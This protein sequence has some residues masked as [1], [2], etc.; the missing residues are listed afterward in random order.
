[1]AP[2][3]ENITITNKSRVWVLA[4]VPQVSPFWRLYPAIPLLGMAPGAILILARIAKVTV[5]VKVVIAIAGVSILG[6]IPPITAMS[7]VLALTLMSSI[8]AVPELSALFYEDDIVL[9]RTFLLLSLIC[10]G[11]FTTTLA[12]VFLRAGPATFPH[13]TGFVAILTGTRAIGLRVVVALGSLLGLPFL[14][15]SSLFVRLDNKPGLV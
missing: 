6:N 14:E 8:I 4:I 1:M 11:L 9:H 2:R 15:F 5:P 10:R 3:I 12:M 13:S 7:A